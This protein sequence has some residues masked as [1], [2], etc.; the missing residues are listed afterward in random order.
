[1]RIRGKIRETEQGH[2]GKIVIGVNRE[3]KRSK[4]IGGKLKRRE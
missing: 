4:D 2:R 3:E 1:M